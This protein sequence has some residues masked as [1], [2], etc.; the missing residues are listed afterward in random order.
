MKSATTQ[1]LNTVIALSLS[2][3]LIVLTG[4]RAENRYLARRDSI[5][6][7]AGEAVAR[8]NAIQ[9]IN[10]WPKHSQ[11]PYFNTDGKRMM[12]AVERYQANESPEPEGSDTTE[13]F[14]NEQG[15]PPAP[16]PGAPGAP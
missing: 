1:V 10:P 9:V 5:T 8:N 16:P 13:R 11:D 14:E 4:C 7:G 3:S 15:P 2:A 12:V 6:L